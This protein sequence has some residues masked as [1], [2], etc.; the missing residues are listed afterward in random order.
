MFMGEIGTAEWCPRVG[1]PSSRPLGL[2]P[3]A[4]AAEAGDHAC[5]LIGPVTWFTRVSGRGPLLP[6]RCVWSAPLGRLPVTA[7]AARTLFVAAATR[8]AVTGG[9]SL[10]PDGT[11]A[12]GPAQ[13]AATAGDAVS[14]GRVHAAWMAAR[15]RLISAR[16]APA[17]PYNRHSI[18]ASDT[19]SSRA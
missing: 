15:S 11:C 10:L 7:V 17:A 9:P 6:G 13:A 16:S 8:I 4:P 18:A 12:T 3:T 5:R 1:R 2:A 19:A 14:C